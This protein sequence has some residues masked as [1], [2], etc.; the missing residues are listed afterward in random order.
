MKK[1]YPQGHHGV[2]R[3]GRPVYI[4]LVGKADATKVFQITT[5]DQYVKYHVC[6]FERTFDEKFPA[7]SVAKGKLINK[8]T[9][10]MDVAGFVSVLIHNRRPS[11]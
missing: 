11:V 10:I 4:E 5:I 8:T 3:E 1:I 6:E 2:D 7:C 9:T